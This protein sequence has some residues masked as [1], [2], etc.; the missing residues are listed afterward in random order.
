[1]S[2]ADEL[3]KLAT[4]KAD[5]VLTE[6]EFVQAKARLIQGETVTPISA[7]TPTGPTLDQTAAKAY[8]LYVQGGATVAIV[9]ILAMVIFL[10]MFMFDCTGPASRSHH[11]PS[12][13]I[14]R[15]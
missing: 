3:Q 12:G 14:N 13:Y 5:G 11:Q 6:A 15:H 2:L 4:L 9:A 8:K 10:V 7:P 1:M